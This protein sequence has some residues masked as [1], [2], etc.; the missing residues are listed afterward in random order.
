MFTLS[1]VAPLRTS[2]WQVLGSAALLAFLAIPAFG[3]NNVLDQET[4]IGRPRASTEAPVRPPSIPT[5][6]SRIAVPAD[7]DDVAT[8]VGLNALFEQ[9]PAIDSR[10]IR[11][12]VAGNVATITGTVTTLYARDRIT[13]IARSIRGVERV[14]N[15]VAVQPE[16]NRSDAQILRDIQ[17]AL[18]ADPAVKDLQI[19]AAVQDGHATLSGQVQS[20][21]TQEMVSGIV[22]TVPGVVELTSRLTFATVD[23]P[24]AEI[25]AE[26]ERRLQSDAWIDPGLVRLDVADG[27]VTLSG[28][29][30]SATERARAIADSWVPGV[31]AV[32]ADGLQVE[33]NLRNDMRRS[34]ETDTPSD[35]EIRG[36]VSNALA[37]S[38]VLIS[39]DPE[40]RVRDG[41]VTLD[42]VVNNRRAIDAAEEVVRGVYGVRDVVNRLEVRAENRD[43]RRSRTAE[44]VETA[45]TDAESAPAAD[46]PSRERITVEGEAAPGEV[47][48]IVNAFRD[49]IEEE[50]S[51]TNAQISASEQD[52][53]LY[54]YGIVNSEDKKAQAERI[55]KSLPGVDNVVNNITVNQNWNNTT[56]LVHPADNDILED[57]RTTFSWN[58]F[59]SDDDIAVD[60]SEGVVTL[61][62]YVD[63]WRDSA[64]AAR[65]AKMA[66]ATRVINNLQVGVTLDDEIQEARD[67]Q[68]EQMREGRQTVV[69][70]DEVAVPGTVAPGADPNVPPGAV[71]PVPVDSD[72]DFEVIDGDDAGIVA[73]GV[74][75]GGLEDDATD[76]RA[77]AG[78]PRNNNAVQPRDRDATT[79]GDQV[80]VPGAGTV[81]PS[82]APPG[83]RADQISPQTNPSTQLDDPAGS[84]NVPDRTPTRPAAPSGG[85]AGGGGG[86]G[87]GGNSR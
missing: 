58:A 41:V 39:F 20:W 50:S 30:A 5:E 80:N 19:Q 18:A 60:V 42:G 59:L 46:A 22:K 48:T 9:D 12:K 73:G 40:I 69:V 37:Y 27:Q 21:Q 81:N 77:D 78:A 36:A 31:T 28:S 16:T 25:K 23:R 13:E 45:E 72:R 33:A 2:L 3:Q 43:D 83:P 1:R 82:S 71:A 56:T 49:A 68:L 51:L 70:E 64:L 8:G 26:I 6:S 54:L 14:D 29:V 44:S 47:P 86:A 10:R 75:G 17:A 35:E 11:V 4:R 79:G 74:G 85:A 57:I 52:D 38:P 67:A 76:R 87:G 24:D 15:R 34:A 66:G 61:N 63:S 62:G 53:G 65:A 32:T 7:V 55:A 84:T